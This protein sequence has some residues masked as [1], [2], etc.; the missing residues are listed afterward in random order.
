[1]TFPRGTCLTS[2]SEAYEVYSPRLISRPAEPGLDWTSHPPGPVRAAGCR[3]HRAGESRPRAAAPAQALI[4]TM[5]SIGMRAF[6][7]T[8]A[9]TFTSPVNSR[10]LSRS[11][12]SVIIFM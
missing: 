5:R 1:M 2:Y 7:A 6:S 11:L 12:G 10:R 4:A 8:P 9:G 3:P